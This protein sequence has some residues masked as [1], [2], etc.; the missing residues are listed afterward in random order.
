MFDHRQTIDDGLV[1]HGRY[2]W[3]LGSTKVD[4]CI[5][6]VTPSCTKWHTWSIRVLYLMENDFLL[7]SY[8]ATWRDEEHVEGMIWVWF[9]L[10]LCGFDTLHGLCKGPSSTPSNTLFGKRKRLWLLCWQKS[11]IN[12]LLV[13]RVS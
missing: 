8:G 7:Y 13:F 3:K 2:K 11:S 10:G 12:L 1:Y 5:V 9:W 6:R 4:K